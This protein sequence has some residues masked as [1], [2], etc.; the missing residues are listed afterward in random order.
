MI[1]TGSGGT[2]SKT[3][4]SP[5]N[6]TVWSIIVNNFNSSFNLFNFI[7]PALDVENGGSAGALFVSGPASVNVFGGGLTS[8]ARHHSSLFHL[9]ARVIS[10]FVAVRFQ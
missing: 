10:R 8:R 6:N 5:Q 7:D 4:M 3:Y 2:W 1:L 9:R